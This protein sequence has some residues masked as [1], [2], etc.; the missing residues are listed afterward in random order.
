MA[1]SSVSQY[2]TDSEAH[3]ASQSAMKGATV[4]TISHTL[5]PV[6]GLANTDRSFSR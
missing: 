6:R 1:N 4:W 3:A 2:P 5:R